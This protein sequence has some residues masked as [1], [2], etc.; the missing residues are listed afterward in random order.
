MSNDELFIAA[1]KSPPKVSGLSNNHLPLFR[2]L[3]AGQEYGS[4]DWTRCG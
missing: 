2:N 1:N 4:A 3:H